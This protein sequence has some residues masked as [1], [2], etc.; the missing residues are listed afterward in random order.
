MPKQGACS[1][2]IRKKRCTITKT[3]KNKPAK[4]I[5][6]TLA[7]LTLSIPHPLHPTLIMHFPN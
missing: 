4:H 1:V 3:I 5:K 7:N 2:N 6:T